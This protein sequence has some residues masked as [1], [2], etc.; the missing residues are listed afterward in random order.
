MSENNSKRHSLGI[1]EAFHG[2]SKLQKRLYMATGICTAFFYCKSYV[3]AK[4]S[5]KSARLQQDDV[6]IAA[7]MEPSKQAK[8]QCNIQM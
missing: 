6:L 5:D 7:I 8:I 1:I 3:M 4:G 2:Y